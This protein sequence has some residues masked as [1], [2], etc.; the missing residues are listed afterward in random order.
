MCFLRANCWWNILHDLIETNNF[1]IVYPPEP[2][3]IPA[4]SRA[5]PSV[6]DFFI[7]N[8]PDKLSAA[9]SLNRL[10]SDHLPVYTTFNSRFQSSDNLKHDYHRA[11]W[12]L[13]KSYINNNVSHILNVPLNNTNDIELLVEQFTFAKCHWT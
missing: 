11:N 8:V 1:G 7:S 2:T 4:N 3:L 10:N 9:L 12:N 5:N 13:F 6:L